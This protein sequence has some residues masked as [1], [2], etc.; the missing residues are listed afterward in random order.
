MTGRMAQE[1]PTRWDFTLY[2]VEDLLVDEED[3][4]MT[5]ELL[6]EHKT[7]RTAKSGMQRREQSTTS[8]ELSSG[9]RQ[10]LSKAQ[11]VPGEQAVSGKMLRYA[12]TQCHRSRQFA[13]L[14]LEAGKV[15]AASEWQSRQKDSRPKARQ[16]TR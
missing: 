15:E 13:R 16:R 1:V 4:R 8:E 10:R 6:L 11:E 9:N 12:S 2:R 7:M 5:R 14:S 3:K